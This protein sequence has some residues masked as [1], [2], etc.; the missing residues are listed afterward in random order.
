MSAPFERSLPL[1]YVFN[2]KESPYGAAGNGSTDDTIPIQAAIT[3]AIAAGGGT[4]YLPAGTYIVTDE[5][6]ING[7]GVILRGDSLTASIIKSNTNGVG[8]LQVGSLST[9]GSG[10]SVGVSL[11]DLKFE[12]PS[13]STT[14]N[15][16][17]YGATRFEMYRCDVYR[18]LIGFE[19]R[20]ADMFSIRLSNVRTTA[21]AATCVNLLQGS[22][23]DV[24]TGSWLGGIIDMTGTNSK[25]V[26]FGDGTGV[27]NNPNEFNCIRFGD[28]LKI[29][30][31][32]ISGTIGVQFEAGC[33]NVKF[34]NVEIKECRSYSIDG[35]AA[36]LD[37]QKVFF[38]IDNCKIL[39]NSTNK[40]TAH[41]YLKQPSAS[42]SATNVLITG[43]GTQLHQATTTIYIESGSP[44]ISVSEGDVADATN[45]LEMTAGATPRFKIGGVRISSSSVTN[46]RGTNLAAG[47]VTYMAGDDNRVSDF[48]LFDSFSATL[49]SGNTSVAFSFSS[50]LDYT[51]TARDIQWNRTASGGGDTGDKWITSLTTTGGTLNVATA[52][53]AD[54]TYQFKLRAS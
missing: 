37:S 53:G 6:T 41:I 15:V 10:K 5:L 49:L 27:S 24:T 19:M 46:K 9:S 44:T 7:D 25:G 12:C 3:A 21:S 23:D 11:R 33:R 32:N 13:G 30:G 20:N 47:T 18:G 48:K 29:D 4:V 28:G 36:L 26:V 40:P 14:T 38:T 8:T 17:V 43:A 34:E 1:S 35:V 2:V 52:A 45:F 16:Q 42:G 54:Q 39:G 31:N 51:P 22:S 50:T